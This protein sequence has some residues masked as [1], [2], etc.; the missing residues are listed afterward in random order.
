MSNKDEKARL[1]QRRDEIMDQL[2]SGSRDLQMELD[3]DPEEQA[4]QVEQQDASIAIVE[5][6]RRE[7]ADV[8][9]KLLDLG[10]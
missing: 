10:D 8:E 6:L 9:D 7:L 5:N 1:E 2:N 4:I 3:R